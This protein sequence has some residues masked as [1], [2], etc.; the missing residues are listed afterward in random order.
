MTYFGTLCE[1]GEGI[2]ANTDGK[3][4]VIPHYFQENRNFTFKVVFMKVSKIRKCQKASPKDN[5]RIAMI[6]LR[7]KTKNLYI[8]IQV[9]DP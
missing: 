1:R 5:S 4:T 8:Y 7:Q 6:S 2:I 3:D 9:K